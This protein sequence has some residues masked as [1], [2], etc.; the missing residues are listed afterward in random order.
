MNQ[1]AVADL[2]RVS[3]KDTKHAQTPR[4]GQS[5]PYQRNASIFPGLPPSFPLT[6]FSSLLL[7]FFFF[8]SLS[9]NLL[10]PNMSQP[11]CWPQ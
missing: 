4:D 10:A 7:L 5:V 3:W 9:K 11:L 1:D 6:P 2:R 8:A